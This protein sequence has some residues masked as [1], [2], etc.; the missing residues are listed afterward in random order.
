VSGSR[1]GAPNAP[2]SAPARNGPIASP[3]WPKKKKSEVALAARSGTAAPAALA[4]MGWKSPLPRG[5]SRKAGRS[6]AQLGAIATSEKKSA[7][8]ATL[9]AARSM[10]RPGALSESQPKTG[11]ESEPTS[12]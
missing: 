11:C 6:Q 10:V 7:I 5:A 8:Q 3:I 4:P 12:R 2:T 9:S 1:P